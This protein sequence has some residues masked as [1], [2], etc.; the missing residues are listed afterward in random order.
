MKMKRMCFERTIVME[1]LP[2]LRQSLVSPQQ[3][4][5]ECLSITVIDARLN[6]GLSTQNCNIQAARLY[7]SYDRRTHWHILSDTQFHIQ[8]SVTV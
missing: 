7:G 2:V 4:Q 6:N 5:R 8:R 3:S 1:S